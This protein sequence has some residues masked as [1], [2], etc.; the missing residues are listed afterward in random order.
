MKSRAQPT[1]PLLTAQQTRWVGYLLLAVQLPQALY[2]PAWVALL[3]LGCVAF[4]LAL[5]RAG[6]V[7]ERLVLRFVPS[8]AL[9]ILAIAT[10]YLLHVSFGY[11]L[12]RDPCVAFLF[13]LVGIKFVEARSQRD[14]TLLVCL[15]SFLLVTFFFYSQSLLAAAAILPALILLASSLQWLAPP[16]GVSGRPMP[17]R[18]PLRR[19]A[20]LL[21]EGVPLALLLFVFFPRLAAPLWGLPADYAA[22]TGLSDRMSPGLIS[23]LSLSDGIAFRVDFQGEI[24]P[25]RD[26]YW[27]GPVFSRFD[28]R[29]WTLGAGRQPGGR[30]AL[31]GGSTPLLYTV[32]LEPNFKA[33]LFALDVAAQLPRPLDAQ[34]DERFGDFAYHTRDGQLISRIPVT[35]PMRY[36]QVSFLRDHHPAVTGDF[37]RIERAENLDLPRGSPRTRAFARELR[38]QYANDRD[39]ALAILAWFHNEPFVYTLSPPRLED[40]PIDRFLFE[41]RRGFC[42]HYASSFVYLL[43][44]AGIPARVVTGYQGGEINPNGGYMIVRQSDAHAWAEALI[45]GEWRRFDPTAAVSPTR[46]ELGLSRALGAEA[47]IAAFAGMEL[48]WIK[49]IE[50][51]WDALNYGWRQHVVGFNYASQRGLWRSWQMEDWAAW[52]FVLLGAFIVAIW[53]VGLLLWF[54][55]RHHQREDRVAILWNALCRRLARA[56]LPR[57]PSEGPIDYATR[58]ATRWPAFAPAFAVIGDSYAML[59]YGRGASTPEA[60]AAREATLQRLRHAIDVLPRPRRLRRTPQAA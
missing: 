18:D 36:S 25:P 20:R 49:N 53:G 10:A 13:V 17:I 28:G 58:A 48:G 59:R 32:T 2:M 60:R 51:A 15:A 33:S 26:R 12:G 35:Q 21:L 6:P 3:G 16:A 45:A 41:T 5:Q 22:K 47:G 19:A 24:P 43:R 42:E 44:A 57:S 29:E 55:L 39:L 8:W 34:I 56:G 54:R 11:F 38:E 50:L 30:F 46:I 40:D 37:G 31:S 52:Q 27:R 14:G 9:G 1:G 23:E 4:R 7:R